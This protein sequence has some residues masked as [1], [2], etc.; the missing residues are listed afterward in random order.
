M[1]KS[2]A[3]EILGMCT[4]IAFMLLAINWSTDPVNSSI[5]IFL[6]GVSIFIASLTQIENV[7]TTEQTPSRGEK[8]AE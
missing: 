8:N 3:V 5:L 2:A 7:E 4:G 6:A 1:I